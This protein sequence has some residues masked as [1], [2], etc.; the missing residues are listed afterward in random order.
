MKKVI[1]ILITITF[2]MPGF[3][4]AQSGSMIE[5]LPKTMEGSKSFGQSLLNFIANLFKKIW[6]SLKNI[7]NYYIYPFF[8]NI[9]HKI[10]APV[11]KEFDKRR[12]I[13]EKEFEEKK[14]EAKQE[15]KEVI[16]K[17]TKSLW[18]RFKELIR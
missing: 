7:W 4:F 14:E 12:S 13:V 17:T 10:K 6:D 16:P 2:L 1:I 11:E 8:Q 15:A 3:S 18:E 5:S 9:W